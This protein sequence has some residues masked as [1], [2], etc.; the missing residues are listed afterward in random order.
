MASR[1]CY[2]TSYGPYHFSFQG[3]KDPET[4]LYWLELIIYKSGFSL[5]LMSPGDTLDSLSLSGAE[6]LSAFS[7]LAWGHSSK[8]PAWLLIAFLFILDWAV[9]FL[10][11]DGLLLLLF[12]WA[13]TRLCGHLDGPALRPEPLHVCQQELVGGQGR[14]GMS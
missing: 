14:S 11:P 4:R 12:L 9:P 3:H 10:N 8:L 1:G 13:D 7:G 5:V 6:R 2:S